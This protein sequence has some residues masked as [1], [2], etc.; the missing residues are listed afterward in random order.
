MAAAATTSFLGLLG[1]G[2]N[3]WAPQFIAGTLVTVEVSVCSYLV[4]IVLG[5]VGAGGK[6]SASRPIRLLSELYTTGVRSVPELLLIIL[7]F[8]TGTSLL[9][10]LVAATG[11]AG[12][13]EISGFATA[14]ATLGFVQGAYMTEVFRGAIVAISPG[15]VEAARALALSPLHRFRFVTFPL[16]LRTALPGMGNLWQSVLKE[17]ALVSVV[18]FSELLTVGKNAAGETK[19]YLGFFL[20]T[21]AIYLSLTLIS[22]LGFVYLERRLSRGFR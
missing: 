16:M 4:G 22:N 9:N 14:V 6:L 18:G 13:V 5:L 1:F 8:Y 3:G 17:S 20:F 10:E 21:A 2:D 11:N 12:S 15:L 7:L 19:Y